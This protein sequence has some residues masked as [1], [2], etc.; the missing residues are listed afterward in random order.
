MKISDTILTLI[1]KHLSNTSSSADDTAL[2]QWREVSAENEAEFKKVSQV[3]TASGTVLEQKINLSQQWER[4]RDGKFIEEKETPV[5][6]LQQNTKQGWLK[7]AVAAVVLIGLIISGLWF[8]GTTTYT[9]AQNE[10][11]LVALSDGTEITLAENSV[12]EVPKTFNWKNR[13]IALNG[14]GF[15][16]IAKNPNKAF[17]ISGPKTSTKILG[18]AFRLVATTMQNNIDV[19]EGKVAYWVN[20]Q[21][22]TLILTPGE[23]AE[24]KQMLLKEIE[25][26]TENIEAWFTG[27]YHFYNVPLSEVL[28]EVQDYY[29]FSLDKNSLKKP[30]DCR[31]SGSFTK[32]N[33]E[34][35]IEELALAMNFTYT[36]E[37]NML[38]IQ[39][40]QCP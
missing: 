28:A 27:I 10:R 1:I 7:Y 19:A 37:N 4:F 18:T 13:N 11:L 9:T 25:N 16:K 17:V 2:K 21:S 40:L 33:K 20:N 15:F 14:E 34:D 22:D 12:L 5:I 23:S 6:S 35:V 36:W 29:A 30:L 31:F 38:V 26:S 32:Q 39:S 3:W 24:Y 8:T